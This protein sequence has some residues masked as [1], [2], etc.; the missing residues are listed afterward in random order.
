MAFERTATGT[1]G[2]LAR[3][4][5]PF[6][7]TERPLIIAH[8]T[9][10]LFL[11]LVHPTEHPERRMDFVSDPFDELWHKNYCPMMWRFEGG[12]NWLVLLFELVFPPLPP[13]P[14]LPLLVFEP[15]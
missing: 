4:G 7:F 14:P 6:H 8:R 13:F 11:P 3:P 9:D 1:L 5:E 10:E 2:V 15:E 12:N